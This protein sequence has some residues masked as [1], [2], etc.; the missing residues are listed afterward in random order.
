MP[1]SSLPRCVL[2][3]C[4]LAALG[5]ADARHG[6]PSARAAAPAVVPGQHVAR[7]ALLEVRATFW[8]RAGSPRATADAARG[9]AAFAEQHQ[10]WVQSSELDDAGA[11]GQVTL[12]VPPDA[13]GELRATLSRLGGGRGAVREQVTRTDVTDAIA[14]LDARLRV[15]RATEARLLTLLDQRGAALADVLAVER[16][17]AEQRTQ[18]EQLESEQRGAQ[19]RVDLATVDVRFEREA[20]DLGAPLGQQVG[21][22]AR[23]GVEAAR[24]MA[25]GGVLVAL[26][27]GP[28]ALL[29]AALAALGWAAARALR[30]ARGPQS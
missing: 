17:L 15:A 26:R 8:V 20:V 1:A 19:G 13:L 25:V 14:D 18:I 5:C 10:G 28:A 16:A 9:L 2:F 30:R 23:D 3:L 4:A 22:A 12:R 29:L 21:A 24:A 7:R 11:S 6:A 27:A